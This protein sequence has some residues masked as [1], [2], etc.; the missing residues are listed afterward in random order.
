MAPLL[1]VFGALLSVG[2]Y[3]IEFAS[4]AA[5]TYAVIGHELLA[6]TNA[7]K[8]GLVS[9]IWWPPLPVLLRLPFVAFCGHALLPLPSLIVSAFMGAATLVFSAF[10]LRLWGLGRLRWPV[11]A[12]LALCPGFLAACGDGSSASTVLCLAVIC[13]GTLT[14]WV[15]RRQFRYLVI[16]SFAAACLAVTSFECWPF[17]GMALMLFLTDLGSRPARRGERGA[18]LALAVL[19][20]LYALALWVLANR[21]IMG[22]ALYFVRSLRPRILA[23]GLLPPPAAP[24]PWPALIWAAATA[25]VL[26]GGLVSRSRPAVHLGLLAVTPAAA[27]ATLAV[28]GMTWVAAPLQFSVA[29]AGVLAIGFAAARLKRRNLRLLLAC[30]P[31]LAACALLATPA[32]R[33]APRLNLQALVTERHALRGDIRR[34]LAGH[35][36]PVKVIVCGYDSLWLLGPD[37]DPLF[38]RAL[39]FKVESAK[40]A[41]P[42][43][44]LYLMVLRPA[45]R[46]AM[47]S[48]NWRYP[49]IYDLGTRN[50]LYHSDWGDWRLFEILDDASADAEWR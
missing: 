16:G 2:L 1:V 39:D 43:H 10:L 17:L 47:D 13:L 20:T 33:P 30:I 14:Q 28:Y 5:T 42:G 4:R 45:G 37:P 38:L 50:M 19:P 32:A 36:W 3:R 8:Q 40:N 23:C 7:G 18:L 49:D 46:S 35:A 25:L 24:L 15:W 29:P 41:Y 26:V 22:D 9:S 6:L 34:R 27:A 11:V 12:A 31:L 44:V 48:H 21:L